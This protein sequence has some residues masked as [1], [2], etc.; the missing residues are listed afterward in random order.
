MPAAIRFPGY[1]NLRRLLSLVLLAIAA[2]PSVPWL[3]SGAEAH[4][5]SAQSQELA[6]NL[7][8][9][10]PGRIQPKDGVLV[11]AAPS[12]LELGPA[13]VTELD[14]S[15]GDWV[16]AG[17]KLATL[18]GYDQLE[19]AHA[20]SVRRV[21]LAKAR[22][23]ALQSG[24]KRDDIRALRAEVLGGET[25]LAQAKADTDRM[26]QLR[27]A[28]LVPVAA[29][30]SQES[31]LKM[32]IQ[33][34]EVKRARLSGLSTVRPSDIAVAEAEL[35]AA[36]ADAEEARTQREQTIVRAPRAGR[37][38]AIYSRPGQSVGA[39]GLLA[40]GR[41]DEMYVD[42]E[43]AEEDVDRARVG[44]NATITGDVLK[45]PVQGVVEDVGLIVGPREVFKSDPT[46]F[47]DLRIVHIKIRVKNGK[48]L[49]RFINARVTVEIAP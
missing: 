10:A 39:E 27:E 6:A 4:S 7:P 1:K 41:T 23:I 20:A 42:A 26:T 34:L 14:V 12:S 8:I 43:V 40:F 13:I 25:Q 2:V 47:A 30:E 29:M 35:N 19:A 49:E 45:R 18:R 37:V 3:L 15:Q 44:Q 9:T 46:A 5:E 21:A 32:T 24:G 17:R 31:R 22:L 48:D 16:E 38:L 36:Q 11:I 28:R 33:S